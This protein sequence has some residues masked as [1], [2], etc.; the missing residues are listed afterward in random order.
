MTCR[1][2]QAAFIVELV[3]D[4]ITADSLRVTVIHRIQTSIHDPMTPDK[5]DIIK[6]TISDKF[7]H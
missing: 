6:E 4:L 1:T 2:A 5:L 7:T 3:F